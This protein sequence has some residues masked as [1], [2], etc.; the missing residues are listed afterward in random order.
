M[1]DDDPIA[2]MRAQI[3]QAD[4]A[5]RNAATAAE[6]ARWSRGDFLQRAGVLWDELFETEEAREARRFGL[7]ALLDDL[8]AEQ[9]TPEWKAAHEAK[10]KALREAEEAATAARQYPILYP[11]RAIGMALQVSRDGLVQYGSAY[12][13]RVCVGGAPLFEALH[14]DPG[15]IVRF[16]QTCGACPEQY[17]AFIGEQR[18]G[19]LR[20]RHGQFRVDYP[21]CGGETIYT[22]CPLGDGCFHDHAERLEYLDRA[23][24]ALYE[25]WY[26]DW[27]DASDED[28]VAEV[29]R[30]REV[31]SGLEAEHQRFLYD[32]GLRPD[33]D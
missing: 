31:D 8:I 32:A 3:Q 4:D 15:R 7:A 16:E 22:D 21:E 28:I 11:A 27:H 14:A 17:D 12:P 2:R 25:R 13:N 24:A 20:L 23:R 5:L 10:Q 33:E 9:D 19:Y 18:M 1:T 26:A 29:E 30:Q 6:Q